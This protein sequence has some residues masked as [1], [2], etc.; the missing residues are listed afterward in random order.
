VFLLSQHRRQL[1]PTEIVLV[2]YNLER[3][4]LFVLGPLFLATVADPSGYKQLPSLAGLSFL[5][6]CTMILCGA[7]PTE[8]L[9]HTALASIYL[10]TVIGLDENLSLLSSVNLSSSTHGCLAGTIVLQILLLYDRGWQAQRW[11]IPLVLGCTYG[12]VLGKLL[13]FIIMRS[14]TT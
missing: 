7:S 2:P 4:T 11:P 1:D 3:F 12:W 6:F 9:L 14:K 8:N 5:V 13:G 10:S